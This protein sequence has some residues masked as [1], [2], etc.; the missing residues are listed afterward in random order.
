MEHGDHR[1]PVG[2]HPAQRHRAE[3][4][5]LLPRDPQTDHDAEVLQVLEARWDGRLHAA[6]HVPEDFPIRVV[7]HSAPLVGGQGTFCA[8][9]QD[10]VLVFED[11]GVRLMVGLR[12]DPLDP[13]V[14]PEAV[15]P[16]VV[17]VGVRAASYAKSV[18]SP[19]AAQCYRT[20][21]TGH[22]LRHVI[23][24]F[25]AW[26]YFRGRGCPKFKA[27]P[28]NQARRFTFCG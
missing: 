10:P 15:A 20:T 17:L 21:Q 11:I 14:A 23:F 4:R 3:E 8:G 26:T 22:F 5:P 6:A 1:G 18:L 28:L 7:V 19:M 25:C 13:F 2:L 16:Q 12:L 24:L 27:P 9:H